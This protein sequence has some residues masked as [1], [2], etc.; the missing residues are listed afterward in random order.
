MFGPMEARGINGVTDGT[1]NTIIVGEHSNFILASP[2]GTRT[3]IVIGTHGIMM[4]GDTATRIE[5]A[6]GGTFGRQFN[7]TTVRYSPNAPAVVN[8]AAWPGIGDN[9][10]SNNPLNSAHVG[11]IHVL[12]CDGSVRFLSDNINMLTL[13]RLCTRDD[14]QVIGEF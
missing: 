9:F 7:L 5:A 3:A 8:D 1:T 11:G 6:P 10:G 14:G 13:R 12:L 4:G 2:G